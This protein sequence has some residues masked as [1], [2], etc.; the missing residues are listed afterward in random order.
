VASAGGFLTAHP[1]RLFFCPPCVAWLGFY[2]D[3]WRF[4]GQYTVSPHQ[5]FVGYCLE[6]FSTPIRMLI[7]SMRVSYL[8]G[9]YS[10]FGLNPLGY[11]VVIL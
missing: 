9:L 3:D 4:L 1:I 11:N 10:L 8:A 7:P 5:T 2:C 6:L